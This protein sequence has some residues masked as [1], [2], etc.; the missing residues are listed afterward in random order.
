MVHIIDNVDRFSVIPAVFAIIEHDGK[1]LLGKRA[2][3]NYMLGK[4][5]LVSGHV[6]GGEPLRVALQREIMEEAGIMV[7]PEAMEFAYLSHRP[8]AEGDGTERIDLFFIIRAFD[9]EPTICEPD[10]CTHLDWFSY[11]DLPA[12]IIPYIRDVLLAVRS[13]ER[14]TE[15][16]W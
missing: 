13:G 4:Y 12:E 7:N 11:D 8:S 1:V 10:K 15:F 9:G 5:G 16:G 2:G 6:D 3:T 14:F